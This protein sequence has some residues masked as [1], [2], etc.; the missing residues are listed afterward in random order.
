[1]ADYSCKDK[2]EVMIVI[3]LTDATEIRVSKMTDE[4]TG[5]VKAVDIRQ[6]FCTKSNPE[7]MPG[8]GIRIKDENMA[9]VLKGIVLSM[10]TEALMDFESANQGVEIVDA[11]ID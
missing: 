4:N 8:K 10:S 7:M 11:F 6:W 5:E 1:M 3:K 9:E 2:Q